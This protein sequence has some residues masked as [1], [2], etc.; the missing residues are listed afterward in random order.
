MLKRKSL[1][2]DKRGVASVEFA[3]ICP[4][5]ILLFFGLIELAEGVNC[6][7]RMENTAS[8]VADLV[9]QSKTITN[10]D[11]ANIFSAAD[12]L[13]YPSPPTIKI[14]VSSLIDDGNNNNTGQVVWSESN[15]PSGYKAYNK[16][17]KVSVPDGVITSGGASVIMAEVEFTYQSPLRFILATDKTMSS[18]FYS[19]PRRALQVA[20]DTT[21]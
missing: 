5:L 9:A 11:V 16:N 4:I 12:S 18:Q 10:A 7:A 19:R 17:D 6:R 21:S 3:I 20:R 1:R 14:R 8:T 15:D 13:M 2:T